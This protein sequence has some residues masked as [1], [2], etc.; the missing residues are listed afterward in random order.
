MLHA[1]GEVFHFISINV[2]ENKSKIKNYFKNGMKI[3][4]QKQSYENNAISWAD[5]I[6]GL[7]GKL[8]RL[9]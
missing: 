4:H 7:G 9:F 1:N 5:A 3:S 8:G 6:G 2:N